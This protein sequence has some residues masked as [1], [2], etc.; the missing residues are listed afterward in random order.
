MK[1]IVKE[2]FLRNNRNALK[3]LSCTAMKNSCTNIIQITKESSKLS[4]VFYTDNNKV[5][6]YNIK[7]KLWFEW[8]YY[9]ELI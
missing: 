6:N 5:F 8:Y 7:T 9:N 3:N 2:I 1:I 4:R